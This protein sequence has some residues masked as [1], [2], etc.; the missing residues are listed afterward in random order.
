MIIT[1]IYFCDY[2][3]DKMKSRLFYIDSLHLNK[4]LYNILNHIYLQYTYI[5]KQL[6]ANL[7]K[8]K[9]N[10]MHVSADL[11][12]LIQFLSIQK[13]NKYFNTSIIIYIFEIK[14]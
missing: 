12:Y 9:K 6:S 7:E 3:N 1:I 10:H 2:G 14:P 13:L 4:C 8:N 11:S 5:V